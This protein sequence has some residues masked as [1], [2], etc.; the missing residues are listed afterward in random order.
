MFVQLYGLFASMCRM[1][2]IVKSE[3]MNGWWPPTARPTV[4]PDGR[5][6]KTSCVCAGRAAQTSGEVRSRES[7]T[8]TAFGQWGSAIVDRAPLPV[9]ERPR[10]APHRLDSARKLRSPL[11]DEARLRYVLKNY[12]SYY[13]RVR[14]HLSLDK[15][16]PD[17]SARIRAAPS[18]PSQFSEGCITIRSGLAFD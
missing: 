6:A 15:N 18:Q 3:M 5:I 10:R 11:F 12:T 8:A 1:I 9:A 4:P 16:A 14:T 7:S 17:S 13:N 2:T